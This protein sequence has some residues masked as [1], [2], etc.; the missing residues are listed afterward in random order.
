[1]DTERLIR[2]LAVDSGQPAVRMGRVWLWAIVVSAV[3]AAVVFHAAIGP[4]PD[5]AAAAE[6]LRFLFKFVVTLVLLATAFAALKA[7]ARP[8]APVGPALAMLLVAPILLLVAVGVE[9]MVV[10][11]DQLR[12]QWIGSNSMVCMTFIP[13]IGIGPLVAFLFALAA[14]RA[15]AAVARRCGRGPRRRRPRR[16]L[17]RRAL[18]RQL[19]ALR[20]DLVSACHRNARRCGGGRGAHFRPLVNRLRLAPARLRLRSKLDHLPGAFLVRD[21]HGRRQQLH[22]ADQSVD[23]LLSA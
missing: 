15:D 13:L 4:R 12:D 1:M 20:R 22:R 7:L 21:Q 19:A 17:L 8:G 3:V 11:A 14:W 10:P 23:L 16:D 2:T 6:T 18:H 9:M 5:I